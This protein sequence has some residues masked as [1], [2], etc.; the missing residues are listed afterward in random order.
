LERYRLYPDYNKF[1]YISN[2]QGWLKIGGKEYYPTTG[3][4]YLL[5]AGL[6]QSYSYIND[7]TYTK[8]WCHFTAKIGT[9]NLFDIIK[10][11]YFIE[12]LNKETLEVIFQD[13]ITR[14]CTSAP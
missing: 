12:I 2:D 3:Q 13:L 9:F 5:P 8:Y 10:L 6:K 14:Y 1:Y 7:N 11:P 4:L